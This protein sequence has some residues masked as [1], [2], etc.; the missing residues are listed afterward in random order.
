MLRRSIC[1]RYAIFAA[2][3]KDVNMIVHGHPRVHRALPFS[4]ALAKQ[5]EKARFVFIVS[6]Y[7]CFVDPTHHDVMQSAWD[8]QSGLS[9]HEGSLRHLVV[10]V[11]HIDT[12]DTTSPTIEDL[13]GLVVFSPSARIRPL[14]PP[15]P[16]CRA[17]ASVPDQS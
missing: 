2:L 8:T 3:K 4:D 11:E 1:C 10:P 17:A 12:W 9:W 15:Y 16:L 6:E 14:F 5:L 13:S 7:F